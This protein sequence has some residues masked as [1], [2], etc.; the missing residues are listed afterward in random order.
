VL[1][2]E[3]DGE[4][5]GLLQDELQA[6]G[7]EVLTAASVREA[8]EV[9]DRH[10]PDLVILDLGLP[11]GDGLTV[12]EH[13][14]RG[15]NTPVL[16]LTAR[17]GLDQRVAGL[18]A[19]AD[20]YVVKPFEIDEL[21]ARVHAQLRRQRGPSPAA[22]RLGQVTLY[23]NTRECEVGGTRIELTAR[24]FE[25]LDVLLRHPGR[26]FSRRELE[27]RFYPEGT[28]GE[29]NVVEA[30]ISNVRRKLRAAGADR[31][32]R[33]IRGAGYTVRELASS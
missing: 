22:L 8:Q 24:E 9:F 33:T 5:L 21:M 19:G 16:V 31:L 15:G 12:A 18:Y 26:V 23:A 14:R 2:V 32:I 11:D 28:P 27:N 29:S 10:L 17:A 25:L 4:I 20:D 13:I 3:D 30:H 7:H 1:V 6:A